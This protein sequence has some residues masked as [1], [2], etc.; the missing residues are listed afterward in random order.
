MYEVGNENKLVSW[1]CINCGHI[2]TGYKRNDDKVKITCIKCGS[3][4]IMQSLSRRHNRL[5]SY[6]PK[7]MESI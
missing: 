7:G 3:E 4:Q 2:L 6:A 1:Y 5:D